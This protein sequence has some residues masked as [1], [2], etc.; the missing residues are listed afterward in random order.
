MNIIF[1]LDDSTNGYKII[2]LVYRF[3]GEKFVYSTKEKIQP[4]YWDANTNRP[5]LTDDKIVNAKNKITKNI[6]DRYETK[7]IEIIDE[8]KRAGAKLT[9][10]YL[11]SEMDIRLKFKE[12]AEK[13]IAKGTINDFYQLINVFIDD[14]KSGKRTTKG[15]LKISKGRIKHYKS[16]I[17]ILKEFREK[18]NVND[19]NIE[20][21]NEFIAFRNA[22]KTIKKG[23]E[24]ITIQ[25]KALNTI[26]SNINIIKAILTYTYKIRLHNNRIFEEDDFRTF[27]EDIE[28]VY[29]S[30]SE[31]DILWETD[32]GP[33]L[34]N[35]RDIFLIGCYTGL[36]ITDLSQLNKNNFVHNDTI[37]KVV[38]D[39]T[40]EIVFIP[41]HWRIHE[42]IK[43]N[44]GLPKS[45]SDQNA[46]KYLKELG[47]KA[48]FTEKSYYKKTVGGNVEKYVQEKYE[49]I[50]NH[51]SRRSFATNM[52][53]AGFDVLSI[54]KITG[55]QSER[56]FMKYICVTQRQMAEK[57]ITHPYFIRP[58]LD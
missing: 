44:N 33:R 49:R 37:L 43:I 47:Q 25:G 2:K 12:V 45:I 54:M 40:K 22:E 30:D 10:N 42:I 41:I 19:I 21:Y 56:M 14:S 16:I 52:Y 9:K 31:L 53:L 57:M 28:N 5:L 46:N 7:L 15:G 13:T 51:T 23:D 34:N 32:F 39:K 1:R 50:T 8:V 35:V 24:T 38:T 58:N 55:H 11:K 26:G 17:S 27:A 48:G 4:Q 20:F 36:R 3:G 18:I 6:L 29:I